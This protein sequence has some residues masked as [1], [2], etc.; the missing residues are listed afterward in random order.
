MGQNLN[1]VL[2]H[3]KPPILKSNKWR[4]VDNP[5][6]HKHRLGTLS[7]GQLDPRMTAG[8]EGPHLKT[9]FHGWRKER[10]TGRK[11]ARGSKERDGR[12]AIE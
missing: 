1:F 2:K 6:K 3:K 12:K 8:R 9:T 11:K 4:A 10:L 7:T 5:R